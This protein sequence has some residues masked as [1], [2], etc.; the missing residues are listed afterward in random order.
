MACTFIRNVSCQ[1]VRE[2]LLA[3]EMRPRQPQ[4]RFVMLSLAEAETVR[5]VLHL[6]QGG[7]A[8]PGA[9]SGRRMYFALISSCIRRNL[10]RKRILWTLLSASV[11]RADTL[12]IA[13][14][15]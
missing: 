8:V 9:P 4:R 12:V 15:C 6:R 7:A 10:R 1:R 5:R 2:V 13:F 11:C 14:Y 3:A